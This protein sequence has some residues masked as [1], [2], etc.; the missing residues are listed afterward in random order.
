[1]KPTEK[2]RTMLLDARGHLFKVH[3]LMQEIESEFNKFELWERR[4]RDD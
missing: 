4:K 1:M 3:K 2:I